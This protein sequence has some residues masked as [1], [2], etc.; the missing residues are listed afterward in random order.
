M[1]GG[2]PKAN[3][4]SLVLRCMPLME[5]GVGSAWGLP[6]VAAGE[7][8]LSALSLSEK[9]EPP[10]T[11][12]LSGNPF[13]AARLRELEILGIGP[14][15]RYLGGEPIKPVQLVPEDFFCPPQTG[16][17]NRRTLK[18]AELFCTSIEFDDTRW[19]AAGNTAELFHSHLEFLRT[20][21]FSGGVYI[22]NSALAPLLA[23]YIHFLKKDCTR[24]K[25]K[26][27]VL[28]SK[29]FFETPLAAE[30]P[31]AVVSG[32][33]AA[34]EI[35]VNIN[36]E[37]AAVLGSDF[38]GLGIVLYED[39]AS[40][41][42]SQ[43]SRCDMLLM[44]NTGPED[45]AQTFFT[46]GITARLKLT[47]MAAKQNTPAERK[48]TSLNNFLFRDLVPVKN[49]GLPA[50]LSFP[51]RHGQDQKIGKADLKRIQIKAAKP[52]AGCQE[53][54]RFVVNSK[55]SGIMAMDFK[56]EQAQF[57]REI[58]KQ[59]NQNWE[60]PP[61][62]FGAAFSQLNETQRDFFF[63]WRS[64]CRR[65]FIPM[66]ANS[67]YIEN[68]ILLYAGELVLCMGREGPLQHFLSLLYLFHA[69][70]ESFPETASLLC[71]WL[72]DF[73]VIYGI[74]AEA[75]PIFLDELRNNGWFCKQEN[76]PSADL[77]ETFLV[78][79]ALNHF[80]VEKA[81]HFEGG[82]FWPLI[83]TLI[84]P[85]I[86]ARK[87]NDT[88]HPDRCCRMLDVIDVQ[89]R[90]DWDRGFFS[91]FYPPLP[92]QSD[93]TAFEKGRAIGDSAYTIYRPGFS[94]HKPLIDILSALALAP[95]TN[96]LPG[97]KTRLHPLS[98]ENEL[99][100]EL[101]QESDAVR[102]ILKPDKDLFNDTSQN[103]RDGPGTARTTAPKAALPETALL[104]Y[105]PPGKETLTEF[106]NSLEETEWYI[107]QHIAR[108]MYNIPVSETIIDAINSAF[109]E[110]FGDLLIETGPEGPSISAEYRAILGKW[111]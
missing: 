16:E 77:P 32:D 20:W 52:D 18:G 72:L 94:S 29:W 55:F 106:I 6:V 74:T 81:E 56:E 26:I 45:P 59:K 71:R 43:R 103:F 11:I 76:D 111:E 91:L 86:L 107:L 19:I 83:K 63:R 75:F 109:Y 12:S 57:Y 93:W 37:G 99:L 101:R 42:R 21:G 87:E 104:T 48:K 24:E 35:P 39:G 78:D 41:L 28:V 10:G 4:K 67:L 8:R 23:G 38:T 88:E 96:P 90:R 14:L 3:V 62:R 40:L 60:P 25:S 89:L 17:Q 58:A 7:E 22:E 80:F 44:V 105:I 49:G 82:K 85:K 1:Y 34:G 110:Q 2:S 98:L 53:G 13:R 84:P 47:V 95:E 27:I 33:P 61:V 97:V 50:P 73:A 54:F 66:P 92:V 46:R 108:G 15:G 100:E 51:G 31:T 65:G 69:S 70:R 9:L 64:E 79:L 68:Y 30:L 36:F 102:D 5:R